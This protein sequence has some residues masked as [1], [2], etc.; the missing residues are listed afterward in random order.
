MQTEKL[1]NF[2]F[3]EDGENSD[4]ISS[5]KSGPGFDELRQPHSD[6][7]LTVDFKWPSL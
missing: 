1:C 5:A 2:R 4:I 6:D 7:P 3:I